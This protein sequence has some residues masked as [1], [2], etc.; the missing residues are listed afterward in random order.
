MN[1]DR[2]QRGRRNLIGADESPKKIVQQFAI[3]KQY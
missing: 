3:I 1:S 2:L